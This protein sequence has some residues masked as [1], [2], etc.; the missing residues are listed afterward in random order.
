MQGGGILGNTTDSRKQ[1]LN[2]TLSISS[3]PDT[4]LGIGYNPSFGKI[5]KQKPKRIKL[6]TQVT[7]KTQW[8]SR[9]K[10]T[11]HDS[12]IFATNH[13]TTSGYFSHFQVIHILFGFIL[14]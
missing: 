4:P 12:H 6:L 2:A 5:R 10:D 11:A 14:E 13:T 9:A 3:I 7:Q 8:H 1:P